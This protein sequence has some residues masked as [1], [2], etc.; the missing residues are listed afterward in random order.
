MVKY[1]NAEKQNVIINSPAT[2]LTYDA[3]K[4]QVR[5][6]TGNPVTIPYAGAVYGGEKRAGLMSVAHLDQ[7]TALEVAN[8][9]IVNVKSFGAVG[10]GTVDDRQAIIDAIKALGEEGGTVYFPTGH[11]RLSKGIFVEGLPERQVDEENKSGVD[12][13][14][15]CLRLQG[16]SSPGQGGFGDT[17]GAEISMPEGSNFTAFHFKGTETIQIRDIKFRG[18]KYFGGKDFREKIN[19][20]NDRTSAPPSGKTADDFV[21][22]EGSNYSQ[23]AICLEQTNYGGNDHL[24][25]NL[26]FCGIGQCIKIEGTG[27]VTIRKITIGHIPP[28]VKALYDHTTGKITAHDDQSVSQREAVIG[29]VIRLCGNLNNAGQRR[30]DQIRVEGCVID[31]ADRPDNDDS[32]APLLDGLLI[33][34]HVN[35]VF[36]TNT[37][38]IRVRNCFIMDY[39]WT[40]EFAYFTNCEAERAVVDGFSIQGGS[41]ISMVGIFSCSNYQNGVHL[42]PP[43][44]VTLE[45]GST[46]SYTGAVTSVSIVNGNIR[47]NGANGILHEATNLNDL[48]VT[49]ARMGGNNNNSKAG[50]AGFK[51]GVGARDENGNVIRPN[52][53]WPDSKFSGIKIADNVN[54][55]HITGGRCGGGGNLKHTD[56]KIQKAGVELVGASHKNIT[57]TGLNV[58]RNITPILVNTNIPSDQNWITMNPGSWTEISSALRNQNAQ[59]PLS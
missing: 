7:I 35:T 18:A 34:D 11:Y 40:G 38:I 20:P 48:S 9:G 29:A 15:N 13:Y 51:S 58:W 4:D 22:G 26:V 54:N 5:S 3:Q 2:N 30:A 1:I 44:T 25:E 41:F 21:N 19:D 47:I 16:L 39:D 8:T 27:R 49:N 50:Y 52:G 57:I 42:Y 24:L 37:S 59:Y 33:T 56:N 10:N 32:R 17:G 45:D 12:V 55:V 53:Q 43:K 23:P 36:V 31:G 6:S 28:G 46:K 14:C